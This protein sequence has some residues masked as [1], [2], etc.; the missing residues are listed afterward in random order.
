MSASANL[1]IE[2][3]CEELPARLIDSQ[4]Q[5][6]ADGLEQRLVEAGLIPAGSDVVRLATPRRLAVRFQSVLSRQPDREIERKGPAENVAFDA[7]GIPTKAAEGFARSIGKS[8]DE[9]DRLETDQGRWLYARVT[10]SGKSLVELLEPML[11]ETVR[12]MAGARSMRWS[13]RS[14]RFLRPVRWLTVLHGQ[15][16]LPISAFGLSAGRETFGHRIH[17]PGAHELASADDY[18]S[19]LEKAHVIADPA[20]RRQRIA[21]Q[22]ARLVEQE[23]LQVDDNPELIDENAGLTEWPVA[24]IGGFDKAFLDVPEEALI[25]SMQQHQ[26]CFPLRGSDGR[27]ADRFVAIAN[28]DSREPEAMIAGFERVIRPRLSDARFFWDQDRKTRLDDRRARLDEVLFQEKLGSTGDKVRRLERLGRTLAP[29]LQADP[30]GVARAA[31]LCKCDL[32]TEMVGEFPELQG[33]MGRYYALADGEPEAVAIAIEE[34]YQPRHA[35]DGLP[36]SPVGKTLALADRLDTVVGIFAA[37]KKPKGGKD[38]FAL[39]RAALGI[40]RILAESATDLT[41]DRAIEAAGEALQDQVPVSQQVR[42]EVSDFVMERLRSHASDAGIETATVQAVSAGKAG[43]VADFLA[44][45][46]AV[47]QFA[48]DPRADSL[49]A[50]NKRTSNLLKQAE[51]V[52]IGDVDGTLLQDDAEKQLFKEISSVEQSLTSSL[53]QADYPAALAALS[54]LK[55]PVDAF[56]DQVMVMCDD[57][58]LRANRLALLKR[59]RELIID[60]ADLARLGR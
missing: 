41:M 22:L 47:Q 39:R 27:L 25:S 15:D 30:D 12:A 42:D 38:P 43:S 21:D 49:I 35:S 32:L 53:D 37:G 59:L 4:L 28:I 11:D 9:L 19:V 16:V 1:L 52:K 44:R 13:D 40:I 14:E 17:A 2:L 46:Q 55:A 51:D 54:T 48:D 45:A 5:L 56:F 8:V 31:Q 20:K 23:G 50:A 10:E 33:T 34:H 7:D 18:E 58:A 24:V 57:P 60:I 6:L 3:G 29:A 36:Q 26:K